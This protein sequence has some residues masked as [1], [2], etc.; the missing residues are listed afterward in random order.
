MKLKKN[1]IAF[2]IIGT[3]GTLS[4]FVY[5]WTDKNYFVGFLF[6]INESVWEHLK[7]LFFPFSVYSFIS[8]F[9]IKEKPNN[10]FQSVV[11]SVICGMF[12]IVAMYY[13]Y[14]GVIGKNIDFLNIIIYF[15]GLIVT[16]IKKNK[17]ITQNKYNT[18]NLFI[19]S[20]FLWILISVMFVVYTYNPLSFGIFTQPVV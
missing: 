17:I 19:L 10:Y 12:S 2:I 3:V 16:L 15:I 4:H 18:Q 14:T 5:E 9:F 7:L 11:F 8:Y 1:V 20:I 13:I 6:P